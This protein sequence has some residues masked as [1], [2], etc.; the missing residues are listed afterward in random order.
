MHKGIDIFQIILEWL[1]EYVRDIDDLP[2][3]LVVALEGALQAFDF[4]TSRWAGT[5]KQQ[6]LHGG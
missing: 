4:N 2:L 5:C 3:R 6:K 1:R